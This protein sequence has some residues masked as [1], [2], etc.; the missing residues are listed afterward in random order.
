MS[1]DKRPNIVLIMVDDMGYSD[2]GCFGA[3]KIKTPHIDQLAEKGLKFTQMY[4]AARCCPTRASLLTG[5]Y[6][7]QAGV[8]DMVGDLGIGPE[9]QG[10]LRDDCVTI[11]E[12]LK[13]AGYTTLMSGKWHV[14]EE[15]PHWPTDRGFDRYFGL[16]SGAANYFDITKTK[17]E[18]VTRQMA[19]DGESWEPP[20]E[21]FYMT[22]AITEKAVDF[23]D[24]QAQKEEPFFL[25]VP[26][27][28]PHWPLHALPED[29]EKYRGEFSQGWDELRNKRYQ[30]LIEAG[31]IKDKWQQAPRDEKV[32]PWEDVDNKE[33]MAQKMAVYAAQMDRMDQGVGKILTHLEEV[34]Q[35]DNTIVVFLSDN[36][37]CHE[38]GPYG[39][40]RRGNGLPPGGEDSYMSYG[41][42]WANLSNTP[43]RLFKH[44]VHEGGISTPL[45]ISWPQ[46]IE[47]SQ[48]VDSVAHVSDL[49]ATFIDLAEA[50]Y[51]VEYNG[52][53]ITPLEGESFRPLLEGKGW[54][55]KKPVFWEHE[56]NCA[57]RD[58]KWKLV[59]RFE[60]QE[61]E[62]Y[63]MAEDRTELNDLSSKR[64]K[65]TKKLK[66]KYEIWKKRCGVQ[67][68][69]LD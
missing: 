55:R 38:G 46:K 24:N 22:E 10:Y 69:P 34:G 9:Y 17:A 47:K 29:I 64:P 49:T 60:K 58:G 48:L 12:V 31:I 40:D 43:F 11:A 19:E 21:G 56:G 7:H 62:L 27:T 57:V 28:A 14:G 35:R 8:G 65:I 23:L 13:E 61:W 63:N 52:K 5:L 66:E 41:R 36:G 30:N 67:E 50:D 68:R 39:F 45:I 16:I 18:G 3:E 6:P 32:D 54:E 53:Q 25:Y 20:E 42:S 44:W 2:L 15:K 26:Y 4:N 37:G 1:K 51:P 59:S 33:E